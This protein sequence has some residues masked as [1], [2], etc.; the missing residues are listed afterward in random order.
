M[1]AK[2]PKAQ[3]TITLKQEAVDLHLILIQFNLKNA[4]CIDPLI[5]G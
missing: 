2:Q 5:V 4:Y 3:Y 1:K